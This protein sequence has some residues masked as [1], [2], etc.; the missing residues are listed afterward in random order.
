MFLQGR[1]HV[2]PLHLSR[3][4]QCITKSLLYTEQEGEQVTHL[5]LSKSSLCKLLQITNLL[6]HIDA[7]APTRNF[8]GSKSTSR[9]SGFRHKWRVCCCLGHGLL[10]GA[11]WGYIP[12]GRLTPSTTQTPFDVTR[13]HECGSMVYF[14]D[15]IALIY[16]I[17]WHQSWP[18]PEKRVPI[19][20][21]T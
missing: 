11:W 9:K 17:C 5:V 15:E 1:T 14:L 8:S 7:F 20:I 10:A 16:S 21:G 18:R 12:G 2:Q 19:G 13:Q 4:R 6:F 3:R